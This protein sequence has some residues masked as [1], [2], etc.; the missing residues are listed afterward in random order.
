MQAH[1][2]P[3]N[4]TSQWDTFGLYFIFQAAPEDTFDFAAFCVF[5]ALLVM[6]VLLHVFADTAA[7][8]P[9]QVAP[10][11]DERR[12]LLA[13]TD[14]TNQTQSSIWASRVNQAAVSNFSILVPNDISSPK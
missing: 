2:Q 6:E 9:H 3:G 7:L 12:P 1:I 13:D 14:P 5:Y 11:G 10:V 8:V 4:S